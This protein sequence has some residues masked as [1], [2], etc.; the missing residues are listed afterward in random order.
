MEHMCNIV[1]IDENPPVWVSVTS[2]IVVLYIL[3]KLTPA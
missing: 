2:W 3:S 1:R